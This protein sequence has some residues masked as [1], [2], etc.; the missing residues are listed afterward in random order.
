MNTKITV[1]QFKARQEALRRF[2]RSVAQDF[3]RAIRTGDTDL[4]WKSLEA[5][6]ENTLWLEVMQAA[7]KSPGA[8]SNNFRRGFLAQWVG[9]GDHIRSEVGNGLVLADGLR[10]LLPVY[11]GSAVML[12]RGDTAL[13]QQQRTY[14]LS[15]TDKA[16]VGRGFALQVPRR[17]SGGGSV[18]LETLAPP[19]SIICAPALLDDRYH[20]GGGN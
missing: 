8:A 7:G 6:A 14:G 13:N 3:A 15:W 2:E 10:A 1:A 19:K 18:L 12:Y 20:C 4:G 17:T 9:H 16:D 5:A 11:T